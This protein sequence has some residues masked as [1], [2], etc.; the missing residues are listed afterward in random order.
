MPAMPHIRYH[1][2][3]P[4]GTDAEQRVVKFDVTPDHAAQAEFTFYA[5]APGR[6]VTGG[7]LAIAGIAPKRVRQTINVPGW[8]QQTGHVRLY[9][10]PVAPDGRCHDGELAGHGLQYRV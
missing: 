7:K 6:P 3:Q 10:F 2:C 1:P 5:R 8:H 9:Q 4:V